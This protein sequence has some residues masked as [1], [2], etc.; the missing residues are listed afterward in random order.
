M[1]INIGGHKLPL[2]LDN[3]TQTLAELLAEGTVLSGEI[4]RLTPSTGFVLLQN[5]ELEVE[6]PLPL[7]GHSLAVG[8]VVE[9]MQ[10][11][12]RGIALRIVASDTTDTLPRL[13]EQT[14]TTSQLEQVLVELNI[15]AIPETIRVAEGLVQRGFPLQKA[16]VWSLLPWAEKG[17]LEEAFLALQAKFP[18]QARLLE[19]IKDFRARPQQQPV[20]QEA[21]SE[22]APD[23]QETF[24]KPNWESRSS[25]STK[26]SEGKVFKALAR[27]VV[28]EQ[29][30]EALNNSQGGL[31]QF[32]YVFALPFLRE[33]DLYAAWVRISQE[34]NA[35]S[36]EG[37]LQKTFRVELEIPTTSFGLVEAELIVAGKNVTLILKPEEQSQLMENSLATLEEELEELGWNLSKL[38]MA[39]WSDA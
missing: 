5:G 38:E 13:G 17:L 7:E 15:P 25:W 29:F 8:Q 12:E 28:E 2:P 19:A 1:R 30:A 6:I 36:R 20:L 35:Q 10:Q 4:R 9:L 26:F 18:L 33:N 39:G 24:A 31:N 34:Q 3:A 21:R 14:L 22:L 23:L 11:G 37:D 27:L 32:E 16:L